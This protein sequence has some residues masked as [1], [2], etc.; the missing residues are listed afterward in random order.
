M[1]VITIYQKY[2]RISIAVSQV[3]SH[4]SNNWLSC[5]RG[6]ARRCTPTE[7]VVSKATT[8]GQVPQVG[9]ATGEATMKVTQGHRKGAI[10][11]IVVSYY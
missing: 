1:T 2:T 7:N 6:T 3:P 9:F 10:R 8:D 4:K 5:C 11:Y